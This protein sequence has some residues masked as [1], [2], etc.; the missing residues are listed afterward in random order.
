M[1]TLTITTTPA[2]DARVTAAFGKILQLGRD[3]TG[4]EIKQVI[5]QHLIQQVQ[6]QELADAQAAA[7]QTVTPI[8]PT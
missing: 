7:L 4:A 8:T 5:I 3:A 2:Q 1:G 6:A